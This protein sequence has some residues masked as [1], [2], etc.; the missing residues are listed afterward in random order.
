[1]TSR[2]TLHLH[3]LTMV[4]S[5]ARPHATVTVRFVDAPVPE[6]EKTDTITAVALVAK[7]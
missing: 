1:M 4:A 5:V 7:F 6:F 3:R 2:Q